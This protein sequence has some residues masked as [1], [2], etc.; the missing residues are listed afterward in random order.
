MKTGKVRVFHTWT[1]NNLRKK[2]KQKKQQENK[3]VKQEQPAKEDKV[4]QNTSSKFSWNELHTLIIRI[5]I[6]W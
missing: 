3:D 5:Y 6:H 4:R 2:D 1:I